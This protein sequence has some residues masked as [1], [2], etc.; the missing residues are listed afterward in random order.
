MR[1]TSTSLL[2]CLVTCSSTASSPWTTMVMC[3]V[4]GSSVGPVVERVSMLKP[5]PLEHP[6]DAREHAELVFDQHGKGVTHEQTENRQRKGRSACGGL[7]AS[8]N[9]KT[10]LSSRRYDIGHPA[11]R[12]SARTSSTATAPWPTPWGLHYRAWVEE[13][14]SR[15]G[16]FPEELFYSLGGVPAPGVVEFLNHRYN[17]AMPV[18]ETAALKEARYEALL[19]Q[20][21][22][23]QPV[24]D[25]MLSKS[26]RYPLAVGSGGY[27]TI[28]LATLGS[29]RHPRALPGGR[30]RYEDVTHPKPAPD[31]YLL[32]AQLLGVEPAR[33]LVF[34]GHAARPPMRSERRHAERPGPERPGGRRPAALIMPPTSHHL[35]HPRTLPQIA[36]SSV[37]HANGLLYTPALCMSK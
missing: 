12:N 10:P 22:P 4:F 34:E 16:E 15:G 18:E 33:C 32:A 29:P 7:R 19:P 8:S 17:L 13:V 36:L 30:P 23:I 31:T 9:R 24:V 20:V 6:G 3:E 1:I 11:G 26:G 5:R 37:A 2:S 21:K 35:T 25:F 27:K 14:S 28:V